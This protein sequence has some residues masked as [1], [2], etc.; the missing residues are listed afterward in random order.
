M[1]SRLSRRQFLYQIGAVAGSGAAYQMAEALEL[2]SSTP[3]QQPAAQLSLVGARHGRRDTS[4]V[5]LG[6]GIAVFTVKRFVYTIRHLFSPHALHIRGCLSNGLRN[7]TI[8]M[9][10]R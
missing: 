4:V 5:I 8:N 9:E 10:G 7:G 6:A 2:I 1:T 3:Q